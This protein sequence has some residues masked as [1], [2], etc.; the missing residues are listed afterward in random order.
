MVSVVFGLIG[1]M[2]DNVGDV[3]YDYSDNSYSYDVGTL[4]MCD[5]SNC[6]V[7]D[8]NSYIDEAEADAVVGTYRA[9]YTSA[10]CTAAGFFWCSVDNVCI[11][12]RTTEGS[13]N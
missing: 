2:P 7:V 5:D 10:E 4:L 1:C 9:D 11:N 3:T 12:K 8:D 6:S 13:C